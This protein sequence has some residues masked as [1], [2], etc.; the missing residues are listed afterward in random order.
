[1]AMA[2]RQLLTWPATLLGTALLCASSL[3]HAGWDVVSF[4]SDTTLI[5]NPWVADCDPAV[6]HHDRVQERGEPIMGAQCGDLRGD[7]VQ[8]M[9]AYLG[10]SNL[11]VEM[12]NSVEGP[13]IVQEVLKARPFVP[14]V[15]FGPG[16]GSPKPSIFIHSGR[17]TSESVWTGG[18]WEWGAI[19]STIDHSMPRG[20]VAADIYGDGK[21]HLYSECGKDVI[22]YTWLGGHWLRWMARVRAES[23]YTKTASVSLAIVPNRGRGIAIQTDNEHEVIVWDKPIPKRHPGPIRGYFEGL[24]NNLETIVQMWRQIKAGINDK[25]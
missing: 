19:D 1:M 16:R 20:L 6:W 2:L 22:E 13:H 21:I 24:R 7:G 9:Y 17:H 15:T 12:E 23:K 18:T 5:A 4:S 11:Y 10:H 25:K 14:V 8:R 3:A